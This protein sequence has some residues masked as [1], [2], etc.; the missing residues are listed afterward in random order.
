MSKPESPRRKGLLKRSLGQ[1]LEATELAGNLARDVTRGLASTASE[2]TLG[3]VQQQLAKRSLLLP[4]PEPLLNHQ[5]RQRL[6]QADRRGHIDHLSIRCGQD[7]LFIKLDGHYQRLLFTLDLQFAVIDCVLAPEGRHLRLQQVSESLEVQWRQAPLLVNWLTRQ[8]SQR[9][10]DLASRLPLPLPVR[11][12]IEDIPGI[13]AESPRR[14][15]IDLDRAGLMSVLEDREWMLDKLVALT[16]FSFLPELGLLRESREL[17]QKLVAQ[18]TVRELRVQP[19]RLD[20][21][22]GLRP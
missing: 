14:W 8:G 2:S 12:L 13:E 16:D 15:R 3:V 9:A 20:L 4:L 19:G 17:L 22:I 7:S 6:A 21:M 10:F 5:L 1:A 11:R 18:L